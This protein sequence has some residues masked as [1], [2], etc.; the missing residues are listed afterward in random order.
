MNT[1]SLDKKYTTLSGEKVAIYAI[2][3]ELPEDQVHGAIFFDDGDV[4]ST[5]WDID[6]EYCNSK[7][8]PTY[9][10]SLKEIEGNNMNII[11]VGE[12]TEQAGFMDGW[13]SESGDDCGLQLMLFT[14]LIVKECMDVV[15]NQVPYP[16]AQVE[17]DYINEKIEQRFE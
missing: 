10:M 16:I 15:E 17:A 4:L 12:L 9:R 6:G 11:K 3:P 7:E 13:F 2:Y 14:K 1:I 8:A 5:T